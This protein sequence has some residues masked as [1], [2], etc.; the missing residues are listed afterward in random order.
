MKSVKLMLKDV[1]LRHDYSSV[2]LMIIQGLWSV[3]LVLCQGTFEV[4]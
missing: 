4:N 3:F 1:V 2:S